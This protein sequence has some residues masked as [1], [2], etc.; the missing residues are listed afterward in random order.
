MVTSYYNYPEYRL[1]QAVIHVIYWR[2]SLKTLKAN[3][4]LYD[5]KYPNT[6][7]PLTH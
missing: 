4:R 1:L 5:Y 6:S 2:R 7:L 3:T